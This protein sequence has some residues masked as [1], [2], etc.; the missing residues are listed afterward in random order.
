MKLTKI[1]FVI[2]L[3]SNNLFANLNYFDVGLAFYN[4]NKLEKAK[5]KFEQEIVYN[6]KSEK[7]YLYLSKIFKAQKKKELEEK[8]LKTVILLNPNNEEALYNLALLKLNDSDYK[9]SKKLVEQ[10]ISLCKNYCLKSKKLKIEIEKS[11]KK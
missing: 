4:E 6:P 7:S 2:F 5:F 3:I 10:L 1:I 9:G 8:N 11:L